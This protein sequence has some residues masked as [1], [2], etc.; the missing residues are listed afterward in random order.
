[1][2][3]LA[4]PNPDSLQATVLG[5]RWAHVDAPRHLALLPLDALAREGAANGLEVALAT[6]HDR[7]ATV[8]NEFGWRVS[9]APLASRSRAGYVGHAAG[10]LLSL[11]LAPVERGG[12]RG[13][14]YTLALRK[15]QASA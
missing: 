10:K 7:D 5:P 3:V 13:S 14:T 2:N 9:L 8:S 11:A 15:P 4:A 6:T 1:M 12:T